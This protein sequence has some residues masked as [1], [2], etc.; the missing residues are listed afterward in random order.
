M[1]HPSSAAHGTSGFNSINGARLIKDAHIRQPLIC[2]NWLSILHL[3]HL[4]LYSFNL[5][6]LRW[7]ATAPSTSCGPWCCKMRGF[8][9]RVA[10][11]ARLT[12]CG[13][14][15]A[16]AL[17]YFAIAAKLKAPCPQIACFRFASGQMS[18]SR[19]RLHDPAHC[20]H[21]TDSM[22]PESLG[23]STIQ[24]LF[25]HVCLHCHDK[26]AAQQGHLPQVI[27]LLWS[28]GCLMLSGSQS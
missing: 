3:T 5:S 28:S 22:S 18:T 12:L 7:C 21:A 13:G 8:H 10:L 19:A 14:L 11:Q 25:V 17:S 1:K 27:D 2:L 4:W 26:K 9:T 23:T 20:S 16:S 6:G 24:S 15:Q